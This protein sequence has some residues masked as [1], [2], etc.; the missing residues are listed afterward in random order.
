MIITRFLCSQGVSR[1]LNPE[2]GVWG[3][4]GGGDGG[5]ARRAGAGSVR[6]K[7]PKPSRGVFW[8]DQGARATPSGAVRA[9]AGGIWALAPLGGHSARIR[10]AN[11]TMQRPGAGTDAPS[12]KG[13]ALNNRMARSWLARGSRAQLIPAAQPIGLA[14]APGNPCFRRVVG[15]SWGD[16]EYFSRFLEFRAVSSE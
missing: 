11:Q 13:G 10:L 16:P 15:V 4:A 7:P 12:G 5:R 2:K 1:G 3:G 9:G 8:W 14:R 6:V